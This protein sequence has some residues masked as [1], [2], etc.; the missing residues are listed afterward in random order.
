MVTFEEFENRYTVCRMLVSSRKY[1]DAR[2]L[3]LEL[4]DGNLSN[5]ER[6]CALYTL[7][8][9]EKLRGNIDDAAKYWIESIRFF[10]GSFYAYSAVKTIFK[11]HRDWLAYLRISLVYWRNSPAVFRELL[12]FH[13]RRINEEFD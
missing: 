1:R 8:E 2:D 7:G 3:L 4:L 12:R 13:R 11:Q 5:R 10:P 9:A 6:G